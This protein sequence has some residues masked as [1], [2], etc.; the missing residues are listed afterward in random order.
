MTAR[1]LRL[2]VKGAGLYE[3]GTLDIALYATDRVLNPDDLPN[4]GSV[5]RIG[6][7]GAIYSQ[8]VTGIAGI[9]ASGK[10]TTLGFVRLA[11]SL[12]GGSY[13]LRTSGGAD[14]LP[15]ASA[16]GTL[17]MDSLFWNGGRYYLLESELAYS[18]TPLSEGDGTLGTGYRIVNET[19]WAHAGKRVSRALLGSVE[20][21]KQASS[22]LLR[23]NGPADDPLVM[24]AD[25]RRL[26]RDDT[27]ITV[28]LG[29]GP[30]SVVTPSKSLLEETLPDGV[31]QA[32]DGSIETMRWD[33]ASE[34]FHLKFKGGPERIVSRNVA[35]QILSTGTI[36]GS[37]MVTRA[38]EI[39]RN[40]GYLLIDEVEQ[41]INKSLSAV[42]IG[43]FT[44]PETNPHGAQ[45]IFTTHYVQLFDSLRRSDGIYLLTRNEDYKTT[46]LKYS[47]E[48]PRTDYRRSEI[49]MSNTIRGMNP[50]HSDVKRLREYVARHVA[51]ADHE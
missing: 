33:E 13:L 46:I 40:G 38:T 26:L 50:K 32:F 12:I 35:A 28:A 7:T 37:E 1:L 42:I 19:L 16:H 27:S 25:Q 31:V 20:A 15:R 45:L 10:S 4:P 22:V 6:A 47:D 29:L 30:L 43:L 18:T 36:V 21:F 9:N 2:T 34:V 24:S 11:L 48:F 23:R 14:N 51:G 41:S 39:L 3:D 5:H 44:S 8:N 17:V 49:I